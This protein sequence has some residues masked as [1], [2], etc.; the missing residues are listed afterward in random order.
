MAEPPKRNGWG[1]TNLGCRVLGLHHAG[2]RCPE[3]D[4]IFSSSQRSP[5]RRR[6]LSPIQLDLPLP[7]PHRPHLTPPQLR[8]CDN[9]LDLVSSAGT[10]PT[11]RCQPRPERST[12]VVHRSHRPN[13]ATRPLGN[14]TPVDVQQASELHS[15]AATPPHGQPPPTTSPVSRSG[16]TRKTGRRHRP[17]DSLR[18]QSRYSETNTHNH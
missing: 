16:D 7:L 12:S 15:A 11:S 1:H 8:Y 10:A 14:G 3:P 4:P 17:A 2:D 18:P 13:G 6:H 5:P 9:Q